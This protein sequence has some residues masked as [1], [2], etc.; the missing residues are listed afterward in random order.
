MLIGGW[1]LLP[2]ARGHHRGPVDLVRMLLGDE[3][4]KAASQMLGPGRIAWLSGYAGRA[5][6]AGLAPAC[7]GQ[8]S[9]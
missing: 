3:M 6:M 5:R 8:V 2:F 9:I 4:R 7:G 1:R